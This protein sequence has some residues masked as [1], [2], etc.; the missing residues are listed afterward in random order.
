MKALVLSGGR[1]R[2]L[3]PI[4]YTGPKQLIPV[5][6]RP[7]LA[8]VLT[9]I[10]RVGIR[11]VG[12]IISPETGDEI[13]RVIG[14]GSDYGVSVAYIVQSEPLGLAHAVKTARG[15]LGD[16]PFVMYLGDNLIGC[17]IESFIESFEKEHA[18]ALILLKSVENPCAFGVAEVDDEG[19]VTGLEEKPKEPKSDLALVGIYLF[20]PRVHEAVDAIKPSWRGEL[21]ITDAVK[22]LMKMGATVRSHI[23]DTWWLDTGKKDDL[24]AANTTVLDELIGRKVPAGLASDSRISGR[25]EIDETAVITNSTLRGPVVVGAGAVIRDS[26]VGPYTSIAEKARVERSAIEHCVVMTGAVISDIDRM[27]DSLVGM[28]ARVVRAGERHRAY[29]L[30]IGEDS[31]VEV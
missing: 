27:E 24:L 10:A 29:R 18:D 22:E 11:D 7:I 20:S 13:R 16:E 23:I 30:I 9:N 15:F 6:N 8:Y 3:H 21:E 17:G 31:I 1:G 28:N 26:F 25:C 12:M 5:A 2:R 19:H 4:T 14:D